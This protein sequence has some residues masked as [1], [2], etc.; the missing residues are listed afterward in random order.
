MSITIAHENIP[1]RVLA[2]GTQ[3]E[4]PVF[5]FSGSPGPRVYI[6]ANIHGPEIAGIGAIHDLIAFLRTQSQIKGSL[7][8][9]PSANP[10][11]LNAKH[12]GYQ[13][14][15]ADP[16]ETV[17]GN[18]NRIYKMPVVETAD[19]DEPKRLA[20]RDFVAAHKDSDL[21]TIKAAFREGIR[22]ALM[23][24]VQHK[25]PYGLSHG[26]KLAS[27]LQGLSYDADYL[28]DLHTAGEAIY[29]IFTFESC[30]PSAMYFDIHH[31]PLLDDT[32]SGVLDEA[33]LQPWMR[34]VKVFAEAGREI[35]FDDFDLEAFTLELGSADSINRQDMH[36]DAGRIINYLRHKGVLDGEVTQPHGGFFTC[37]HKDYRRYRA[38]TGGLVLWHVA[39][40]DTVKA[41]DTLAVILRAYAAQTDDSG[42]VEIPVKAVKDGL[43]INRAESQVVHEGLSLC[44]IMSEI[45][46]ITQ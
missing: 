23:G 19:E 9:V 44:S 18:F 14:G 39:P 21:P 12:N 38:P 41:G 43:V 13:I 36:T 7:T 35:A 42:E 8:I 29:H 32:F 20:L 27:I 2:S 26:E 4:I 28:I 6:Q 34:L 1:I 25:T 31:L 17:V 46:T 33:F 3:L 24:L 16:N 11:G 10:V 40:G 45:E 37:G 15:Y 30:V 22:A 5:R